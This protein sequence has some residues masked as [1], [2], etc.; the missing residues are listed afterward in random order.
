MNN[1]FPFSDTNKRYYT[2]SYYLKHKY[3][4]KAAK[5]PLDAG[6]TCPNRDGSKGWGGCAFC[7]AR[8]SGDTVIEAENIRDQFE[9]GLKRSRQK[10]P[11][12]KGI[13]YFQAY[14]NTYGPLDELKDKIG[15]A[16]DWDDVL[17][18]SVATRPDCLDDEK[19]QWLKS[20]N[21][22]KETWVELGL[23][24]ANDG[25]MAALNRGHGTQVL[26]DAIQQL[27]DAGLKICL[28]INNGLPNES[29][30]D[31][32]ATACLV[33][34][35]HPDAV[36]IHMLHVIKNTKLGDEYEKE[37]FELLSLAEYVSVVCDQLEVLPADIIIE[38]ITG[39]GIQSD[40]IAPMWTRKKT[41]TANEIDKELLRR[42]SWQGKYSN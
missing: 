15:P 35:L 16:A 4:Q 20:L 6:F 31:M 39:D 40:L 38:R 21:D 29:Y 12:C 33:A 37:P 10:W 11:D 41:V 7:S 28:H 18:L 30:E 24:S 25:T 5:V 17:E 34:R 22:K 42:N 26:I 3:G 2:Y 1:P 36:K 9:A 13:A 14:S 27:K 32:M 8:G 19:I 23:Q